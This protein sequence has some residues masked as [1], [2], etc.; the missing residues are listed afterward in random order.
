MKYSVKQIDEIARSVEE[1]NKRANELESEIKESLKNEVKFLELLR[2]TKDLCGYI[3]S[4][5][6]GSRETLEVTRQH[7]ALVRKAIN[8]A[9]TVVIDFNTSHNGDTK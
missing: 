7:N 8:E 2:V 4:A 5:Q 6:W 9:V 3:E 1:M